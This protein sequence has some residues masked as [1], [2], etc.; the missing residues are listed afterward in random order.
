MA[1]SKQAAKLAI[2]SMAAAP[3]VGRVM[4][5]PSHS[6]QI[7]SRPTQIQPFYMAPVWPGETMKNLLVQSRTLSDP[8]KNPLTGWWHEKYFFY[9]K[10]TDLDIGEQLKTMLVKNTGQITLNSAAD[11]DTYHAGNGINYTQEALNVITRE[12]FRDE[13]ETVLQGA[14]DGLPT[15]TSDG[16]GWMQSA[17]PGSLAGESEHLNPHLPDKIEPEMSPTFDAH[18]QQWTAMRSLGLESLDFEDWVKQFGVDVPAEENENRKRPELLRYVRM[19]AYPTATTKADGSAGTAPQWSMAERADKDR[20]FKEPG[21][22]VGVTVTRPKVYFGGQNGS[23]VHHMVNP[24]D[25]LPAAFRDHGYAS[26]KG[27]GNVNEWGAG[28]LGTNP[29]QAYW[30]DLRDLA[31]Y[32]DQFINFVPSTDG[33]SLVPLPDGGLNKR[34]LSAAA[35]DA[36]FADP[37]YNKIRE[38]GIVTTS[39]LSSLTDTTPG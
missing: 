13:D 2:S 12:Y 29:A 37:A 25:W 33:A 19:W 6:F 15:A 34:Y 23:L 5:K 27:F 36:L 4:R 28:P 9:V 30:V 22:I 35:V 16:P 21:F 20:F 17:K 24:L 3:Q 7:R 8:V 10:L 38:D 11:V 39:I 31:L 18:F 32:G 1:I 26:L 14:I